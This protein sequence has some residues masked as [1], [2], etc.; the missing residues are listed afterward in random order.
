MVD[1]DTEEALGPN[2]IGE[3]RVK[4]ITIM[5]GYHKNPEA[6]KQAFDSDGWFRTGDLA[7]YDDNGEIYIVDRISDFINFRSTNVSPAEIETVLM[8]H[9]AVF[10]AAVLGIPNEVDEQHPKAFV[11]QVPNKSVTE[12]ELISYVE[13]NLPYYCRLRG[14][15]KIVDQLPRTTTGKIAKK[16]LRDMYVN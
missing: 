1:L 11:V 12:Q 9:P 10:Q 5:Q 3:L 16:Q 7:Y 15:V 2:K 8:T 6:T 13:K 4:A 14:G